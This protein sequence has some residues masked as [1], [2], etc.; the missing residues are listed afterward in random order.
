[1]EL[2][3]DFMLCY[4]FQYECSKFFPNKST[5]WNTFSSC[6]F[7]SPSASCTSPLFILSLSLSEIKKNKPKQLKLP[8][9]A[10]YVPSGR[11]QHHGSGQEPDERPTGA[12]RGGPCG[13]CGGG[14]SISATQQQRG[15][16][17]TTALGWGFIRIRSEVKLISFPSAQL[18]GFVFEPVLSLFP[19]KER[20]IRH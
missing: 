6:L 1:M 20:C 5:R 4:K 17:C 3:V 11:G 7:F 16:S 8:S 19:L 10:T 18:R 12:Q 13:G 15:D 2:F 9:T 14:L